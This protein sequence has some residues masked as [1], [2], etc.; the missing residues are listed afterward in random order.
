MAFLFFFSS[1]CSGNGFSLKQ[2]A[3]QC[4]QQQQH[5]CETTKSISKWFWI[6]DR[7]GWRIM[8]VWLL[9]FSGFFINICVIGT[10]VNGGTLI[11]QFI[12]I[13][14]DRLTTKQK[15]HKFQ[16]TLWNGV[17]RG[18]HIKRLHDKKYCTALI[19]TNKGLTYIVCACVCVCMLHTTQ[20]TK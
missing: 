19:W 13:V 1:L 12:N 18:E 5:S 20:H 3:V 16:L 14:F 15:Q 7:Q 17:G 11:Q 6:I 9:F 8:L 4:T 10:L 2:K